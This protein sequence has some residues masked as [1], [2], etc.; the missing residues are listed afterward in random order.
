MSKCKK[1]AREVSK[2]LLVSFDPTILIPAIS[3]LIN[4]L[5]SCWKQQEATMTASEYLKSQYNEAS[6]SFNSGLI[7]RCLP[8][9]RRA[10]RIA[11]RK[12]KSSPA[13][14]DLSEADLNQITV[15]ALLKAM[16]EP[17]TASAC[18]SE[19]TGA[20]DEEIPN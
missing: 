9:T 17:Q 2:G 18:L 13:P 10:V 8:R 20:D 6:A 19:H 14:K 1:A 15:Q 7:S 3:L 4:F 16:N 5:M 11:H 12:D